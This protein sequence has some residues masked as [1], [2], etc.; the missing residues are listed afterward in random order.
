MDRIYG[1][2]P[3]GKDRFGIDWTKVKGTWF[4]KAPHFS[5]RA[6][7]RHAGAAVGGYYL[8]PSRP[9]ETIA[10]GAATPLGKAKNCIFVLMNG[11]P[12]HIDTF[13]LKEGPWLPASYEPTSYGGVRW[14]RGLFPRMAEQMESIALVRSVRSWTGVHDLGRNWLQIGRNPISGLGRIAPHIGSIISMEYSNRSVDKTLPAFFN[15]NANEGI[16]AGYFPP[17]HAPFNFSPGGAPPPGTTHPDGQAAFTRRAELLAELDA[18]FRANGVL[19]AKGAEAASFN[20]A[21]RQ[22]MYRSEI[23]ALFRFSND[24][25]L[26][27]GNSGFGNACL[28]ARNLLGS[29]RGTRFVQINVG[30]W[31][32][33]ANIY[34]TALNP[35]NAN[36]LG[37]LFD[38]AMG[39]LI[40]DLKASGQLDDTLIVAMG[41]F[42]R[43]IGTPNTTVGR[44]HFLQQ[45]TLFAGAGIKGGRAIGSTFS[46]GRDTDNPGWERERS[47]RAEDIAATIYSAL[48]IDWTT[49]RHDDPLQRGFE[50]IPNSDMDLYGPIHDLWK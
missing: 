45:A 35:A 43:T 44:D 37:R 9:L 24:E 49:V 40:A 7:F 34:T 47:V 48:G 41:E 26:R 13:D 20:E 1:E 12:S 22:L 23:D 32:N 19:G 46:D 8:L 38:A 11:G 27:Y 4:W 30:S 31:D 36:S 6:F 5:R 17:V 25:R 39:A 10:K 29:N 33:H 16:G 28:V 14:P 42:G 21:A 3:T 15:L 50:Y 18:E 2:Q